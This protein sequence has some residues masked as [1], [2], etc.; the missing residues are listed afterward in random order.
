[1]AIRQKLFRFTVLCGILTLSVPLPAEKCNL[2]LRE[3]ESNYL[4]GHLKAALNCYRQLY[5]TD[6]SNWVYTY[7]IGLLSL[8]NGDTSTA[9]KYLSEVKRLNPKTHLPSYRLAQIYLAKMDTVK[10]LQELTTALRNDKYHLPSLVLYSRCLNELGR[11]SEALEIS[12]KTE[13]R[14]P[15]SAEAKAAY[16][17]SLFVS[18]DP[19]RAL[20]VIEQGF[21]HFPEAELLKLGMKIATDIGDSLRYRRYQELYTSIYPQ[22]PDTGSNDCS[23]SSTIRNRDSTN[24][25]VKDYSWLKTGM[26]YRYKGTWGPFCLGYLELEIHNPIDTLNIT[27]VPVNY[28]VRSN[29][30]L[31]FFKVNDRYRAWLVLDER[32]TLRYDMCTRETYSHFDRR[33]DFDSRR[34]LITSRSVGNDGIISIRQ[35]ELP[36]RLF[37]GISILFF[38][39]MMVIEKQSGSGA[40]YIGADDEVDWTYFNFTGVKERVRVENEWRDA[41]VADGILDYIGIAGMNNEFKGLFSTDGQALPLKALLKV[42]IGS[43]ALT[44]ESEEQISRNPQLLNN[45]NQR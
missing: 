38:A 39:R 42:F 18:C 21:D 35:Q 6:S 37:D 16:S 30:L 20:E 7:N 19:D 34:N 33:I 29:S 40:T 11:H 17:L 31:P 24:L 4:H 44:L 5:V 12:R 13:R 15:L 9:V 3:A 27:C 41:W 32:R 43:I 26:R 28:H 25:L 2:L 10:A 45:Q 1:M 14:F 36:V 23:K 22:S 8:F